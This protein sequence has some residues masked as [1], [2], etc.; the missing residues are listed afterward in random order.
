M[1]APLVGWERAAAGAT[2]RRAE[3][4]VKRQRCWA[5]GLF[6]LW[7]PQRYVRI[8]LNKKVHKPL[9]SASFS[10]EAKGEAG[11]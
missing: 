9:S 6:L 8:D 4:G 7:P 1:A 2:R 10:S 11:T 5:A 3:E